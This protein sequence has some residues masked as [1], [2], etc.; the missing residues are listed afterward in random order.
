M[1]YPLKLIRCGLCI[2]QRYEDLSV[3]AN[4]DGGELNS[5]RNAAVSADLIARASVAKA[6]SV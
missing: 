1:K 4:C 3:R 6:E 5:I 2:E